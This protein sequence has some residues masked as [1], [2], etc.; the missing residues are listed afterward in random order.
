ML[1]LD[2]NEEGHLSS[3]DRAVRGFKWLNE[4]QACDAL[5]RVLAQ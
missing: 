5:E 3:Y 2:E 1:R 4:E